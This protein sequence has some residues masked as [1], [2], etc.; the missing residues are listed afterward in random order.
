MDHEAHSWIKESVARSREIEV[1]ISH[2]QSQPA[3][4]AQVANA[5]EVILAVNRDTIVKAI[6]ILRTE[7]QL[8]LPSDVI[9]FERFYGDKS[10]YGFRRLLRQLFGKK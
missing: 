10:N 5:P 6:G 8:T 9:E 2:L 4:Y 7:Y 3:L 1:W